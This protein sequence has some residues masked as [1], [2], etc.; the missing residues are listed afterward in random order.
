MVY[1]WAL[2]KLERDVQIRRQLHSGG[3]KHNPNEINIPVNF[4]T[5]AEDFHSFTIT[6]GIIRA[7][8]WLT[9]RNDSRQ[10]KQEAQ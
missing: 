5:H 8:F 3:K 9:V 6:C 10:K 7:K 2:F 4:Q 1:N